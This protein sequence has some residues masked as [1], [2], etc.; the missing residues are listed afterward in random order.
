MVE[1]KLGKSEVLGETATNPKELRTSGWPLKGNGRDWTVSSME[2]RIKAQVEKLVRSKALELIAITDKD[3][4]DAADGLREKFQE[5]YTN[6]LY[7]YPDSDGL[8]GKHVRRFMFSRTGTL[9]VMLLLMRR[10][11][12]DVTYADV[13]AL[14]KER[15]KEFVDAFRWALGNLLPQRISDEPEGMNGSQSQNQTETTTSQP[16]T[17]DG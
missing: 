1:Q 8:E 4:P 13:L 7:N 6:G 17:M 16:Q 5:D 3:D 9:Q 10:C 12:D 2:N 11:H 14:A 15:P